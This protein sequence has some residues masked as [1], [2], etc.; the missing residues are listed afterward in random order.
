M[1]ASSG[2]TPAPASG[3]RISILLADDNLIVR[4]GVKALL[5]REPDFD[6]VE[7]AADYHELLAAADS[8]RP[9]VVVTDIRM[10]PTFQREGID[11]AKQIRKQHPGTGVV[12][13]SQF[14]EPEY[15]VSLLSEGWPGHAYLI[16]DR[17]AEGDQLAQAVRSVASSRSMLDPAIVDALLQPVRSSGVLQPSEE[18]LL[19]LLAAGRSLKSIAVVRQTTEAGVTAE[20]ER[21][22]L[23]LSEGASAGVDGALRKLRMLH[24]AIIDREEQGETLSRFLPGGVADLVRQGTDPTGETQRLVVTVLMSDIRGYTS[25]AEHAD[26]TALAGQLNEHR[27]RMNDAILEAGGTVMQYVGDAV[28]AVFGAPL[29]Q[30]DHAG[31]ALAAARA[32]HRAQAEVNERWSTESLLPFELG[33][34][35]ST[36]EVAAAMLGS[37]ERVE[38]TVVGDAVNLS[39][40]LQQ[41]ARPGET[42]LSEATWEGLFSGRPDAEALPPLQVKGRETPVTAY[43]VAPG[44]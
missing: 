40:R 7:T 1:S 24:Q 41:L 11:A 3:H 10:P 20:I 34:G 21:L 22:F 33:I 30:L 18:A 6:V 44:G 25:I 27:A 36:G 13:L 9:D 39:A 43:R 38:Y 28:M 35:L 23:K 12:V 16:K 15:A 2:N 14:D 42:V 29:P 26:P 4:E 17:V 37:A 5:Q 8:V 32:M 31:H 19:E